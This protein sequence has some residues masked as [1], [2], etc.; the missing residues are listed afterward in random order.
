MHFHHRQTILACPTKIE[1]DWGSDEFHSFL[2]PLQQLSTI[3]LLSLLTRSCMTIH[4]HHEPMIGFVLL[5][6]SSVTVAC[7]LV[8]VIILSCAPKQTASNPKFLDQRELQFLFCAHNRPHQ[9]HLLCTS[10]SFI[11]AICSLGLCT[12]PSPSSN[13]VSISA[14]RIPSSKQTTANQNS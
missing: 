1:A 7:N 4:R 2:V 10:N 3:Y 11:T 13:P 14:Q 12:Q 9:P 5:S 6:L 8:C